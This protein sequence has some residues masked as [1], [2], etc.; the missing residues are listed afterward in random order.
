MARILIGTIPVIGHINPM[1]PLAEVRNMA[2]KNNI[3][4]MMP[5]YRNNLRYWHQ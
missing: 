5:F 3:S 4:R 1:L 2:Q